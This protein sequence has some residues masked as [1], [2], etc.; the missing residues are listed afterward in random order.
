[1]LHLLRVVICTI[2]LATLFL[3][4][5]NQ[6][7][8]DWYKSFYQNLAQQH[9][10][11]IRYFQI[12][13]S[14]GSNSPQEAL[15]IGGSQSNFELWL[16]T[17]QELMESPAAH[18]SIWSG[19][20]LYE[21][22][23]DKNVYQKHESVFHSFKK[24]YGN[25]FEVSLIED[26]KP[27]ESSPLFIGYRQCL[28][29]VAAV[30]SDYLRI[31][32][33]PKK[34]FEINIYA[35]IDTLSQAIRN[36]KQ[37]SFQELGLNINEN[38]VY[39][40]FFSNKLLSVNI[41]MLVFKGISEVVRN[42]MTDFIE[43]RLQRQKVFFNNVLA[44]DALLGV[45][46]IDEYEE[47]LQKR[48][49]LLLSEPQTG[50]NR[51]HVITDTVS[52]NFWLRLAQKGWAYPYWNSMADTVKNYHSWKMEG[53]VASYESVD[54]NLIMMNYSLA[55]QKVII[56]LALMLYDQAYLKEQTVEWNDDFIRLFHERIFLNKE[57]IESLPVYLRF[58]K[59]NINLLT[60]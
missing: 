46:N 38:G 37:H 3:G 60:S 43:E 56:Q 12:W 4:A 39:F 55:E 48:V 50:I 8:D 20:F 9:V 13:V 6:Q 7:R 11:S 23:V 34:D 14:P 31:L 1:M 59:N 36:K 28:C 51:D 10:N 16:Q 35:D 32:H 24:K 53:S 47:L 2:L 52:A 22:M 21:I 57:L 45:K 40:P 26:H 54:I 30:C 29:G 58:L 41:D 27:H 44:G 5:K 33:T 42:Y 17:T 15:P 49:F 19:N 18:L 25:N